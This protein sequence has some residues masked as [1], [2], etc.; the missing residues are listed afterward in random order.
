MTPAQFIAEALWD[1]YTDV[2][3]QDV[4]FAELVAAGVDEDEFIG[5]CQFELA[6]MMR[7]AFAEGRALA[8]E[9]ER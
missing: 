1:R 3:R 9:E 6:A 8:D 4:D 2:D 7:L 5:R